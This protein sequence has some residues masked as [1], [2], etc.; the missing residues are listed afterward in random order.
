ML[1][2]QVKQEQEPVEDEGRQLHNLPPYP[3]SHSQ[4]HSAD[5]ADFGGAI[6]KINGGK[7]TVSL[8]HFY[9]YLVFTSSYRLTPMRLSLPAMGGRRTNLLGWSCANP[10]EIASNIFYLPLTESQVPLRRVWKELCNQ[11]QLEQT[12]AGENI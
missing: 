9:T 4:T 1:A 7:T 6:F 8:L 11:Q 12:Q 3:S 10:S 2:A 5:P